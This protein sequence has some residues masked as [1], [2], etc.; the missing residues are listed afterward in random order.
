[1]DMTY[2]NDLENNKMIVR[3]SWNRRTKV[4]QDRIIKKWQDINHFVKEN[5]SPPKNYLLGDCE[6]KYLIA[7]ND[8]KNRESQEWVF[9]LISTKKTFKEVKKKKVIKKVVKTEKSWE[10]IY[11]TLS[12]KPGSSARININ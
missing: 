9:D 2:K 6:D 5:Y 10:N 12:L 7:D 11:L 3:V 8:S 4:S 1:M